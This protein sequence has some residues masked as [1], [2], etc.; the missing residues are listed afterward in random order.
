MSGRIALVIILA[1]G[2][3]VATVPAQPADALQMFR[4]GQYNQAVQTTLREIQEMPRNMDAY[5]VLGWSLLE[6]R[7]FEEALDHGTRALAISPFDPRIIHIVGTAQF[8]LGRDLEALRLLEQ[9]AQILPNGSQIGPI[10]QMM[11]EVFIRMGEFHH[12]DIALTTAVHHR[13][14]NAVWWSRLGFAREQAEDFTHALAAY[15]RAL[16]LSPGLQAAAQGRARVQGR[17][18]S[19]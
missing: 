9:Y 2:C 14:T 10:Y 17:L 5:T 6:L 15:D 12:A 3:A 16:Q 8:N 18:A 19:S 4:D 13:P 1:V 11:G 7:R